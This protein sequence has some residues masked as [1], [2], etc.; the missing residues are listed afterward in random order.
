MRT[1][2]WFVVILTYRML[3][4]CG[5][6]ELAERWATW[7]GLRQALRATLWRASAASNKSAA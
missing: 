4:R 3:N 1:L 2:I 5:Q 7:S 6:L